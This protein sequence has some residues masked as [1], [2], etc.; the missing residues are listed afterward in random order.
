FLEKLKDSTTYT[1]Y[2]GK[3]VEDFNEGNLFEN[4][5]FTFSTGNKI[6]SFFISGV[7]KNA[8][9]LKTPENSL[10]MIYDD[11]EDSIPFKKIP[12][13]LCKPDTSGKFSVN[14][15]K[16]KNY[17]IFA[18][19]DLNSNM[20]A[21]FGED[22]A[23]LDS[24]IYPEREIKFMVDTFKAGSVLHDIID[25]TRTDSLIRDTIIINQKYYNTP[26]NL[27]LLMF[28]E[29]DNYQRV[30]DYKRPE[31]GKLTMSFDKAIT[32]NYAFN[33]IDSNLIA[34]NFIL[35]KNLTNDTLIY[36]IKDTNILALDTLSFSITYV[37]EDSI[38]QPKL[39]TDTLLFKFKEKKKN[40]D[41]KRNKTE[42]EIKPIVYSNFEIKLNKNNLDLNKNMLFESEKPLDKINTEKIKL[43]EIKDTSV[44]DTKE[45]K[46][47]KAQRIQNNEILINFSRPIIDSIYFKPL[48][49]KSNKWFD[50]QQNTSNKYYK[51]KITDEN[52]IKLD[53]IKFICYFDNEFFLNQTQNLKDTLKLSLE[54]QSL[55]YGKREESD[56]I[57]LIFKKPTNKLQ[58]IPKNFETKNKWYSVDN[59]H[60]NDTVLIKITDKN[61]S[62][63]DTISLDFKSLDF[64]DNKSDSS[65]HLQSA[66][67]A[68]KE[69]DLFL[70]EA[71]RIEKNS[72][73]LV[74]S[75][76]VFGE[77]NFE[78]LNF[79]LNSKWFSYTK[80]SSSDTLNFTIT[81]DFVSKMD[82]IKLKVKYKY[83]NRKNEI[84][85]LSDTI[86]IINGKKIKIKEIEKKNKDK[87]N[88]TE[89]QTVHIY[90]PQEFEILKDSFF[91]R[92]YFVKTD[93][94]EGIK[95]KI[96][97]DSLAIIDIYDNYNKE[98]EYEF[99]VQK[100]D[101]YSKLSIN[102]QNINPQNQLNDSLPKIITEFEKTEISKII[103]QRNF[104]LQLLNKSGNII[105][106]IHFI[107]NQEIKFEFLSP[108]EYSLKLIFDKNNNKKWD[109]GNY[110]NK[111]QPERV[112]FYHEK[113]N[114][115]SGFETKIEWNVGRQ[116]LDLFK[117]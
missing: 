113:I 92:K 9:D 77:I 99:S 45:Q 44:I 104:I 114:L 85:D 18:L 15:V 7:I 91:I 117:V 50:I 101:Y 95:Y 96:S 21:D 86:S 2:F 34:E 14:F 55:K 67:F 20:I 53:T 87:I 29:D 37:S 31:R 72:F 74:F 1:F 32:E 33:S 102:I 59:K 69:T 98:Y 3:A 110:F 116:L 111:L 112:I 105:K 100:E 52:I 25:T 61:I 49:F 58:I 90:M 12:S 48:N 89:K 42:Q 22:I 107:D 65:F 78:A 70:S 5:S 13:Y 40:D 28:L 109:T 62:L 79:T 39:E 47:T 27:N 41:W 17:K 57:K 23:F 6:D 66:N 38:R 76:A 82:T 83:T 73:T 103:G 64:I 4:Q 75:K 16:Q 35:E 68:F 43:F 80:N 10:V 8:F 71:H 11:L 97:F 88:E 56:K 115:K 94:K 24:V 106:E 60:Y 93:W 26:N 46:I 81:D 36:W 84:T 30:N 54:K 19:T 51:L 63:L 108:E